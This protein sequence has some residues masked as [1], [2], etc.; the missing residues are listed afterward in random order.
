MTQRTVEYF[1]WNVIWKSILFTSFTHK[2]ALKNLVFI[3]ERKVRQYSLPKS[4]KDNWLL[5]IYSGPTLYR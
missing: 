3:C 5:F 2:T 1:R 4:F